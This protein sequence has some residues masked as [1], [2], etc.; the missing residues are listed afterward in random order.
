VVSG[1]GFRLADEIRY[2]QD[3][4]ADHDGRSGTR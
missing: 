4:A 1:K 2:I 3:Q